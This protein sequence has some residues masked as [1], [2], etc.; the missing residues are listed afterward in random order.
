MKG[1][2]AEP[3]VSTIKMP[4]KRRMIMMG[5]SQYFFLV[6]K[7]PH[8]SFKNCMVFT[9]L[10]FLATESTEKKTLCPLCPLWLIFLFFSYSV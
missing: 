5:S 9:P 1:A 7:K 8:K 4:N 6:L 3:E 10:F 2:I